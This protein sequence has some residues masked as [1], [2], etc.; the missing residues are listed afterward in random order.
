M[1]QALQ[2][3]LYNDPDM[4][5][6]AISNMF[7]VLNNLANFAN[8]NVDRGTIRLERSYKSKSQT[9][10]PRHEARI[11]KINF[12]RE[13]PEPELEFGSKGAL[14]GRTNAHKTQEIIQKCG[15]KLW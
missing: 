14:K 2:A 1:E 15:G 13:V 7:S 11:S 12:N 5:E 10:G 8:I 3:F 4:I 6:A 9:A